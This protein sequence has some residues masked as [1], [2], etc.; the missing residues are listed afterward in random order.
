MAETSYQQQIIREVPRLEAYKI[1]LID[2]ARSLYNT[3]L[4]LPAYEVAG[5]SAGQIQAADLLR[6]GIGA[7]EPFMQAGSQAVTQGQ[8]LT[9]Q[10]ARLAGDLNVAPDYLAAQT[11]LGRG[12]S[13][14]DILGGYAKTAGQGLQDV[15]GGVAGIEQARLGLP[16]YMQGDLS[17]AQSL[18]GEAARGT[19]AA[20]P[21]DFTQEAGL[22]KGSQLT[23]AA[24]ARRAEQAA[25][26]PGLQTLSFTQPGMTDVYMSPYMQGVVNI[27]QRE[28]QRQADIA[29]TQ[30][31]AQAVGAGAFG[32]SRQAVMEAEADRNLAQ[33]MA[34]IQA[35]GLQQAYQQAQQQFN[36]E[37]QARLGAASTQAGLGMQAAAQRFQQ[38]GFDA[39]TAMQLAQLE[40]TQRQQGLQQ[41]AQMQGIAGLY[42]Q[43]GMQQAQLGQ[44]GTQLAGQLAGQQAQLGMMP[45]QIAQAQAGIVGQQAGLYGQLGQ[46]LGGLSAQRAGI[47]LQR[48]AQLQQA[49]QGIGALGMQQASL[50]QGMQQAGQADV[51]A[52]MGI[53][54]MEQSNAQAQLDAMRAT[55]MQDV[56]TPYQQL[57]FVADIYK[58]AP[59]SQSALIATSQP[60]ASPFQTAAG[61]GIAG[62]SAAAG[63]K[64]VGLF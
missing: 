43:Q 16:S 64:K 30:R 40:Q 46:G 29:R 23:A 49:G 25:Q 27:Q 24:A 51:S 60:S 42:G 48:A 3:P 13:S 54:A 55:Q 21:S 50:G 52:L 37:Q 38:A 6:Q 31:A 36:V 14:A 41:A 17:T 61:L 56:M 57:G 32:G 2:E 28:A 58:G 12:L 22:L 35:M 33:Q 44:A 7:Y 39:G 1:G 45:A 4:D 59:S 62:L 53:G 47:D 9:Q 34:D 63:A 20:A 15:L 5:Q 10:G 18:L 19:R 11:A 8:A 26:T